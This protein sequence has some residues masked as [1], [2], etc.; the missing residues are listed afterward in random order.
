MG[1]YEGSARK[2]WGVREITRKYWGARETTK[3]V[4]GNIG[5]YGKYG[6]LAFSPLVKVNLIII[7]IDRG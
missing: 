7:K 1:E 5:E 2:H 3:E 6:S 4:R